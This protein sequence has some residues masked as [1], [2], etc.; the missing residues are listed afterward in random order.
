M[1]D[2]EKDFKKSVGV[3]KESEPERMSAEIKKRKIEKN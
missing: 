2:G 3:D 1:K